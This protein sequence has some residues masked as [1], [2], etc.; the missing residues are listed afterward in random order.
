MIDQIHI[1]G[2][3]LFHVLKFFLQFSDYITAAPL[4]A[5]YASTTIPST[6]L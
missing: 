5:K 3:P 6:I 1:E 4:M 2:H